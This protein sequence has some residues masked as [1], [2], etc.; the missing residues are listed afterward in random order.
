MAQD[1]K[2]INLEY[3]ASLRETR[4]QSHETLSTRAGT[5]R[6]LYKN[7]QEK[8]GFEI[9][10]AALRV[11][12]NDSFKSWDAELNDGDDVVFIPPVSGG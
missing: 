3:F 8:Y 4:G 7:L 5:P 2:E 11:A 6:E 9:P 12:V 10:T 1:Q